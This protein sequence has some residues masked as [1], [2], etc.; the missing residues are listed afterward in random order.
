VWVCFFFGNMGGLG[1]GGGML[2]MDINICV[3]DG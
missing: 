1:G 3:M 2:S